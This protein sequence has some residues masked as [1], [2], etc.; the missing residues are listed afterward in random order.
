MKLHFSGSFGGFC[1]RVVPLPDFGLVNS[2][3]LYK[4]RT[5]SEVLNGPRAAM[6]FEG[7]REEAAEGWRKLQLESLVSCSFNPHYIREKIRLVV[8]DKCMYNC[9]RGNTKR[10]NG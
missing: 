2:L 8:D 7:K 10:R 6:V 9:S 3:S 4:K 5:C 1:I